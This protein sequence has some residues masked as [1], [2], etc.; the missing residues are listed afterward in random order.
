MSPRPVRSARPPRPRCRANRPKLSRDRASKWTRNARCGRQWVTTSLAA[1]L[2]SGPSVSA[3]I[4]TYYPVGT[5]LR[6][7]GRQSGWVTPVDPATS[8]EGS[9]YQIYLSRPRRR[10]SGLPAAAAKSG[11]RGEGSRTRDAG[12]GS[13]SHAGSFQ[14]EVKERAAFARHRDRGTLVIRFGFGHFRV[15]L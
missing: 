1:A 14:P 7:A 11:I 2:H 4:V 13:G 15:R 8:Q 9:V 10:L 3:P 5:I 12:Q 6:T